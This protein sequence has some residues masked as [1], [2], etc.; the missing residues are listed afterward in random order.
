MPRRRTAAR[1][2]WFVTSVLL[3]PSDGTSMAIPCIRPQRAPDYVFGPVPSRRLGQ[4]LG[5]NTVPCKTCT[6]SCVYCQLG[7]T[8]HLSAERREYYETSPLAREIDRRLHD[9]SA[10]PDYVTFVGCG[11]P[12]LA[13]NMG[14]VLAAV[15]A[16]ADCRKALLTNGALLWMPEVRREALGFDVV[17]PTVAAGDES[18]YRKIHRP[19]ASLRLEKVLSGMRMFSKEFS[20]D[21]WV[22]V[23]LVRGMNDGR[24]SLEDIAEALGHIRA[25]KIHLTA[26]TRPPAEEWVECPGRESIELALDIIPGAT[27]TTGKETGAFGS[28]REDAAGDL[29]AIGATHPMREEQATGVLV[30]AGMRREEALNTLE[31]LVGEG[32]LTK[33]EHIGETFYRTRR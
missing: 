16:G 31:R 28:R 10:R 25:D 6:Y 19:H 3:V 27:D 26:P 24:E 32:K 11:E 2:N 33:V 9:P 14:D 17:M 5:V 20:G 13:S 30:A 1:A 8:E 4:S 7:R 12:T 22:E 23:M 29:L 18:L 21:I 15:S